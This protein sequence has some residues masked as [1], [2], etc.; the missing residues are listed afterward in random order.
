MMVLVKRRKLGSSSKAAIITGQFQQESKP[1]TCHLWALI[2][3]LSLLMFQLLH[4]FH[5]I[6]AIQPCLSL[7]TYPTLL[8][9]ILRSHI[10]TLS[11]NFNLNTFLQINVRHIENCDP[12]DIMLSNI[13]QVHYVALYLMFPTTA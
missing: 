4:H 13:C 12:T 10:L 2:L 1:L 6:P 7:K 3:L 8:W 5:Q 9:I 11:T